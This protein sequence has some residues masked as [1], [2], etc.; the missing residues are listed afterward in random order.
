MGVHW[1]AYTKNE[2]NKIPEAWTVRF[3]QTN[4][5]KTTIFRFRLFKFI[6]DSS[7]PSPYLL[8]YFMSLLID[9]VLSGPTT[10]VRRR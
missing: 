6:T 7:F 2:A 1:G 3:I 4:I 9:D 5:T 8:S 10:N